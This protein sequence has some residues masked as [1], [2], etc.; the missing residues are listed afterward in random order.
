MVELPWKDNITH[1]LKETHFS[2][3]TTKSVQEK[4]QYFCWS[5]TQP[6]IHPGVL[7]LQSLILFFT[8][9]NQS[10]FQGGDSI[11]WGRR[12]LGRGPPCRC[13]SVIREVLKGTGH[14][15]EKV[16]GIVFKGPLLAPPLRAITGWTAWDEGQEREQEPKSQRAFWFLT[17]DS[18]GAGICPA[19]QRTHQSI[20]CHLHNRPSIWMAGQPEKGKEAVEGTGSV[21]RRAW[22][23]T[24]TTTQR[25][26][27]LELQGNG[28]ILLSFLP[29]HQ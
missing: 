29:P 15:A 6:Y 16:E 3:S 18:V 9:K 22:R 5:P 2:S 24:A 8:T 10:P 23:G 26:W 1:D 19:F 14:C 12:K 17:E 11:S 20:P 27:A 7:R 21:L 13:Q 25:F 28:F 4:Q